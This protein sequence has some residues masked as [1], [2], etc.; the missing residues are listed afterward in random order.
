MR[1]HHLP[2]VIFYASIVSLGGFLFGFDASVISGVV[3]FI[4]P[5]FGLNDWQ[6]GMVV[7]APTLAAIV[8]GLIVGPTSDLIGRK[9]V[10][11]AVAVLYLASAV[12]SAFAPSFWVLVGARALGG[13]AFGSL[14][15]APLY[16][17]E[18]SPHKLRGRFVSIN[19]M[20][21]V[22]GISLAYFANYFLLKLSNSDVQLVQDLRIDRDIWRWMLGLETL[23][24]L[25]FCILLLF[26]P[27]SP[28]WLVINGRSEDAERVLSKLIPADDVQSAISDIQ[29]SADEF[30]GRRKSRIAELFR[31][32]LRMVLLIGIIVGAAQQITGINAVFFYATSIFEQSGVGKNAA[33]MQAVFVG[34]INVVFTVIA[35]WLVD[36]MGRKPL[37][38]LGLAGVFIS[39][40]V[41]AYGFSRATYQL[42]PEA[43]EQMVSVE[44]PAD[45]N[46]PALKP[47]I[48][49][50][51]DSDVTFKR[52]LRDA[53]GDETV[54]AHEGLL[55]KA[56][57]SMNSYIV[58]VGILG[59]VASFAVSLG[60]V[61]WVLLSELY[62]N[63]IRGL[64][65]AAVG[66]VNSG[67]S[68]GVQFF[69]PWQ[70]NNLGTA[71]TFMIYGL[72]AFVSLVLVSLLLKETRGK[73]LEE[74]E[75]EQ[76]S[77]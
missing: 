73:T 24:A 3:G 13:F 54:S 32:E 12:A 16:I 30:K 51:Y 6:V 5:E 67:I 59:F 37:L 42:T 9:K 10:L 53:L 74:I 77:V 43:V 31:P 25:A 75:R 58:L 20:N 33:F 76:L 69:F 50:V 72:F 17:A 27:E 8:T 44:D 46:I 28:R 2:A 71:W 22:V 49:Q 38:I 47:V 62:P 36:K 34:V 15:L 4:I 66:L 14:L 40:S 18:I 21:I 68:W 11:F 64:A 56:A 57:I 19:Q 61:M 39:M 55:I 48:G 41:A 26:I 35:M 70:L 1:N 23:P 63:A 29:K 7:S 52:A 45:I 65:M 60:P